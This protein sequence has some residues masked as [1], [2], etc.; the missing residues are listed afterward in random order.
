MPAIPRAVS[1]CCATS[2]PVGSTVS[3]PVRSSGGS[4]RR[5]SGRARWSSPS[6]NSVTSARR[7]CRSPRSRRS[8]QMTRIAALAASLVIVAAPPAAGAR[9][10]EVKAVSVT[11]AVGKVEV[12]I[13]LQGAA[14]VREFTLTGPY[15]LVVD[16]VGARLSSPAVQY[17]GENR[18]GVRNVRYSQYRPDVVRV[19]IDLEAPT[20]YEIVEEDG[21]VRVALGTDRAVFA[22]WTSDGRGAAPAAVAPAVAHTAAARV[23]TP[24]QTAERVSVEEYLAAHRSEAAQSQA[25]RIT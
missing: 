25:P 21:R 10:G 18:G 19:V 12:V 3:N 11:P 22:A 8:R 6:R 7:P 15:R 23:E 5:R 4:R 24:R 2:R 1:P 17:D 14:E 13:D 20:D 16:L 9:D